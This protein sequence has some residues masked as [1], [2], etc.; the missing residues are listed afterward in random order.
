MIETML[1]TA[2]A[3]KS[4][5][6]SSINIFLENLWD[7]NGMCIVGDLFVDRYMLLFTLMRSVGLELNRLTGRATMS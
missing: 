3:T 4:N 1:L 7:L 5:L 2:A 6:R